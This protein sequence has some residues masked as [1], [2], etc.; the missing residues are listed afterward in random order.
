MTQCVIVFLFLDVFKLLL[1]AAL[2]DSYCILAKKRVTKINYHL[3]FLQTLCS[4]EFSSGIVDFHL[5]TNEFFFS[6]ECEKILGFWR[7]NDVNGFRS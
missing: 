1:F 6:F 5:R 2:D 3:S 7:F 4:N